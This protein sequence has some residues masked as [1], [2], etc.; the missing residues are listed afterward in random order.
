MQVTHMRNVPN[1]RDAYVKLSDLYKTK[2]QTVF[3]DLY[4]NTNCVWRDQTRTRIIMIYVTS[5]KHAY[6]ILTPLN[7]T[8]I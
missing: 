7:P 6:I 1:E 2:T 5:W 4:K 8:F 3:S